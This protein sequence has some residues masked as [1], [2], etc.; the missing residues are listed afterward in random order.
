MAINM[1]CQRRLSTVWMR[2]RYLHG[3]D[4]RAYSSQDVPDKSRLLR[5]E[6]QPL[7]L[8]LSVPQSSLRAEVLPFVQN[9]D[10]YPG[11]AP[12][13]WRSFTEISNF[14]LRTLDISTTAWHDA[15]VSSTRRRRTPDRLESRRRL[16]HGG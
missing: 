13:A 14:D 10:A 11:Q 12:Q 3:A 6:K 15:R 8:W 1:K 7:S 4:V 9:T 16:L 5:P 2:L